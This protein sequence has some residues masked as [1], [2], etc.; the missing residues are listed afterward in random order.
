[1]SELIEWEYPE[2]V[3]KRCKTTNVRDRDFLAALGL[4]GEAGEVAEIWKKH[5]LHGKPLDREHLIQEMGDVFWYFT[6]MMANECITL[7]E[8]V[9]ANMA[10]LRERDADRL[11]SL[12][13]Q[14]AKLAEQIIDL[15]GTL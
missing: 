15:G 6:L 4:V 5:L 1:M 12:K 2:F 7:D 8:I 13:R 11:S 10:K 14:R 3:D 9:I